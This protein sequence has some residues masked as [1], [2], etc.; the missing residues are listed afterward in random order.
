M[1][2]YLV[3]VVGFERDG[4][5]GEVRRWTGGGYGP[6]YQCAYLIGGL[7]LRALHEELVGGGAMQD[8]AFHDA[9]LEQG[10]IP[11]EAIRL[12][13]RGEEIPREWRPTWR[14]DGEPPFSR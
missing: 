11:I 4:A 14:F 5:E 6:L 8:R 1:I 10:S 3:D 12:A 13:L 2:D 7:Q 9:V